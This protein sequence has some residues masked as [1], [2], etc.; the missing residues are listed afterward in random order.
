[1][2]GNIKNM[3]NSNNI[4]S[5]RPFGS[6]SR[7]VKQMGLNRVRHSSQSAIN[8]Q[9][10]Q[11]GT[12]FSMK[13]IITTTPQQRQEYGREMRKYQQELSR[14]TS[15]TTQLA[16]LSSAT[17]DTE[18]AYKSL[19]AVENR[20]ISSIDDLKQATLDS[21]KYSLELQNLIKKVNAENAAQTAYEKEIA[22]K[23]TASASRSSG[24]SSSSRN[25]SL[26]Y[27]YRI[28]PAVKSFMKSMDKTT[29]KKISYAP[30]K[31]AF[32]LA[33]ASWD[34]ESYFSRYNKWGVIIWRKEV[35]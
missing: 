33:G 11:P 34:V 24:S 32:K 14:Q 17:I 16:R 7:L 9:F 18:A 2:K 21:Q 29:N 35:L 15:Y 30:T 5:F 27:S 23:T 4:K 8:K 22:K 13:D 25:F 12:G 3:L 19:K 1:M 31:T 6:E 20:K 26:L 10:S 28:S